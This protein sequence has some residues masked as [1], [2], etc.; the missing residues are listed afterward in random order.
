MFSSFTKS[1]V[2]ALTKY[3]RKGYNSSYFCKYILDPITDKLMQFIPE[4]YSPELLLA[5]GFF[6][7]LIS[8]FIPFFIFSNPSQ[9]VHSIIC[10]FNGFTTIFYQFMRR[11]VQRQFQ[12]MNTV[13]AYVRFF[14]IASDSLILT[15]ECMKFNTSMSLGLTSTNVYVMVAI[16]F[17]YFLNFWAEYCKKYYHYL[18]ISYSDDG[19]FLLALFQIITCFFPDFKQKINSDLFFW[20]CIVLFGLYVAENLFAVLYSADFT[21]DI[22]T[23]FV[24]GLYIT[25]LSLI[26]DF[27]T[28]SFFLNHYF[29][30]CIGLE[31]G[32]SA[33]ILVVYL[34]LG[35][36]VEKVVTY[37]Q[38]LHF[39]AITLPVFG[40]VRNNV[41]YW[42]Y[43]FWVFATDIVMFYYRIYRNILETLHNDTIVPLVDN[44]PRIPSPTQENK[45][46]N[47]HEI[48]LF[49]KPSNQGEE[50]PFFPDDIRS[51]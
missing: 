26:L 46:H 6:T 16:G 32:Y 14:Q 51:I 23:S 37:D 50:L 39:I 15:I 2:N 35:R 13:N 5:I 7:N 49:D 9:T 4:V 22:I 41:D 1:D 12:V 17:P 24:P 20:F 29:F 21:F 28:Y 31:F 38:L 3:E 33:S 19:V 36:K 30:M 10:L 8:F 43:L 18:I 27:L 47:L 45:I 42:F 44:H 25:L 34:I 11:I 48:P 40:Y